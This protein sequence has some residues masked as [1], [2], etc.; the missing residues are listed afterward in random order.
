MQTPTTYR[1]AAHVL[2]T[3]A[4]SQQETSRIIVGLRIL[5]PRRLRVGAV[6]DIISGYY[7]GRKTILTA[8]K[9]WYYRREF[10]G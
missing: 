6:Y 5:A 3:A 9:S 2:F 8:V 4:I 7:C 10:E 1:V